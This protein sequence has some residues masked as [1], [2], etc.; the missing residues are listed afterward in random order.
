MRASWRPS[1]LRA[2][3]TSSEIAWQLLLLPPDLR[4]EK[5]S[6]GALRG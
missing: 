6:L 5:S 4:E 2:D 3:T 1:E